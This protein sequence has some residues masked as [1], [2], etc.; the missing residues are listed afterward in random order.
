MGKAYA[1]VDWE[2][3][4]TDVKLAIDRERRFIALAIEG[5]IVVMIEPERALALLWK[6]SDL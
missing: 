6:L 5:E 3:L 2:W 4:E 1:P